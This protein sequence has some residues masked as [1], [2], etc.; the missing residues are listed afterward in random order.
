MSTSGLP[1]RLFVHSASVLI[2]VFLVYH[3]LHF[4]LGTVHPASRADCSTVVTILPV[5]WAVYGA[6]ILGFLAV[7]A[8]LVFLAIRLLR[9]WRARLCTTCSPSGTKYAGHGTF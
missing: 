3:I 7:A 6:L 4:T 1:N 2:L 8:A 9:A 5:N